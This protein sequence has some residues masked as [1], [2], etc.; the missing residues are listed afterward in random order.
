MHQWA[1]QVRND[2]QRMPNDV[3]V[4]VRAATSTWWLAEVAVRVKSGLSLHVG[5][6]ATADV[7]S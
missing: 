3:C 5:D 2:S 7:R 6:S 1:R 4:C